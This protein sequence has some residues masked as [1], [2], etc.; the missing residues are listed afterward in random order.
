M[1]W[2]IYVMDL[3]T[4]AQDVAD[5]PDDFVPQPLGLR[6]EIISKIL[7][8]VPGADFSNP[9]YGHIAG[10]DFSIEV[11]L[12]KQEEVDSFAF[13]ARGND[14]AASIIVA[15]LQHLNLRAVD[16]AS[17]SGLFHPE[18]AIESFSKWRAYRDQV[19]E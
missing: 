3:P 19:V 5:I 15:I 1:S 18:R 12:G 9:A 7:E 4:G 11:N 16:T 2:D 17:E 13:H 10:Q 14:T 8:V 6:T